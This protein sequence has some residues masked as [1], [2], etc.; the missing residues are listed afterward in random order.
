MTDKVLVYIGQYIGIG[1]YVEDMISNPTFDYSYEI[2]SGLKSGEQVRFGVITD[3][4]H[5]TCTIF[6]KRF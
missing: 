5:G 1:L 4:E 2:H 3:L 6:K